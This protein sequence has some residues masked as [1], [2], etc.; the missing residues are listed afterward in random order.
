LT[1]FALPENQ[2][3][4]VFETNILGALAAIAGPV[5]RPAN[6][7]VRNRYQGWA[8]AVHGAGNQVP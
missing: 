6:R 7:A 4:T 1:G 8:A 2:I 5:G 3:Q